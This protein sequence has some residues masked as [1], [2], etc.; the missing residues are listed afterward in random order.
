MYNLNRVGQEFVMSQ[1]V[2]LPKKIVV[3]FLDN[4]TKYVLV[5]TMS[6]AI[7]EGTPPGLDSH[8]F[9]YYLHFP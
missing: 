8:L 5:V 2:N 6:T 3:N 4:G 1:C 7:G 9:L